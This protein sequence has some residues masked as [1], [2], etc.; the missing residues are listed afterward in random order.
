MLLQPPRHVTTVEFFQVV[1][2]MPRVQ[3]S[4]SIHFVRPGIWVA[5]GHNFY[6]LSF[7]D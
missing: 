5:V 3:T 6:V 1:G 7:Y 2:M 4:L